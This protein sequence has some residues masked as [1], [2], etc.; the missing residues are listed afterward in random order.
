MSADCKLRS[1]LEFLK[2]IVLL[3]LICTT[4]LFSMQILLFDRMYPHNTGLVSSIISLAYDFRETTETGGVLEVSERDLWAS[5][6]A[7]LSEEGDSVVY[8]DGIQGAARVFSASLAAAE[9]MAQGERTFEEGGTLALSEHSILVLDLGR[10]M[11]SGMFLSLSGAESREGEVLRRMV[12]ELNG[13]GSSLVYQTEEGLVRYDSES[14]TANEV[15]EI[16]RLVSVSDGSLPAYVEGK[17]DVVYGAEDEGTPEISEGQAVEMAEL[18]EGSQEE[19]QEGTS[20]F[21][22]LVEATDFNGI[23]GGIAIGIEGSDVGSVAVMPYA[24]S[25][26]KVTANNPI[27]DDDGGS[28][29][30]ELQSALAAFDYSI[31]TLRRDEE[32]DGTLVYVENHSNLRIA[33]NGTLIYTASEPRRGLPLTKW[34]EGEPTEGYT[35]YDVV[36]AGYALIDS[37]TPLLTGAPSGGLRYTGALYDE[38]EEE[39]HIY[40]D[41]VVSGIPVRLPSERHGAV[42]TYSGGYFVSADIIFRSYRAESSAYYPASPGFMAEYAHIT[43]GEVATQY[44][45]VYNDIGGLILPQYELRVEDAVE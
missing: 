17:L 11:T 40:Y 27:F 7:Y 16:A 39:L 9:I 29:F 42:L 22:P 35:A 37:F 30:N 13:E 6:V 33:T 43:S 20:P 1:I 2:S 21:E 12:I 19:L 38:E 24:T 10:E 34:L 31:S 25:H 41:Y 26:S 45:L 18:Q 28:E 5:S 32:A 23:K 15:R 36:K 4:V 8:F 14:V 3:L 44:D